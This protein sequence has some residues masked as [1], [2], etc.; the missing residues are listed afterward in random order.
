M[1][2]AV[3]VAVI[4][5]TVVSCRRRRPRPAGFTAVVL[6]RV[7]HGGKCDA[8]RHLPLAVRRLRCSQRMHA[9]ACA[10]GVDL[11]SVEGS[12]SVSCLS[13]TMRTSYLVARS[14]P[15]DEVA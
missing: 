8:V 7:F 11:L 15:E 3:A 2:V 6:E 4:V 1:V 12:R 10:F 9:V 5:G 14:R 13:S